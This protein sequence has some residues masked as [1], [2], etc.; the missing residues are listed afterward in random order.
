MFKK[1]CR[2][3]EI[4]IDILFF[5]D[6]QVSG[7]TNHQLSSERPLKYTHMD[8][9]GSSGFGDLSEPTTGSTVVALSMH[10]L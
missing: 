1:S 10:L 5:L 9:A 6:H 4:H 2:N 8:V 7:L 3:N